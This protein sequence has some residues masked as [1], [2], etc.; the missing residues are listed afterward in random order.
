MKRSSQAIVA[1]VA[2]A[3]AGSAFAYTRDG[4]YYDYARVARVDRVMATVD[5]PQRQRDCW[6]EPRSE[7]HPGSDYRRETIVRDI[8]DEDDPGRVVRDEVVESGGYTTTRDERVC[9]TRTANLPMRQVI[10]YDVVYT[11][12]GEDY[13]DRLDH[14]PGRSVRIHVDDGYVELAE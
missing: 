8:D 13:H 1:G 7:Y 6:N 11:Y 3:L 9:E 10:G 14:D 2:L 5:K 12:R 4:S